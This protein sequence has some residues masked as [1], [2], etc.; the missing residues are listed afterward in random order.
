MA[1]RKKK[2]K[3]DVIVDDVD[4]DDDHSCAVTAAY[5]L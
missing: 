4:V 1:A 2:E 5:T 3:E